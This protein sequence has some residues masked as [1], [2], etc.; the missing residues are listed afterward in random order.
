[1]L[2]QVGHHCEFPAN[3]KASIHLYGL[4]SQ[5]KIGRWL[6]NLLN[7]LFPPIVIFTRQSRRNPM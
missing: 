1:M 3:A 5:A 2:V 6:R 4:F 7:L